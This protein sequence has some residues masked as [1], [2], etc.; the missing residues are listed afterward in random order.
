MIVDR[1]ELMTSLERALLVISDK[2]PTP[3]RCHFENNEIKF[4]CSG[5]NGKFSDEMKA[6][7]SG[8]AMEIGFKCKYLID[9]L[10]VIDDEKVKLQMGGSL[11][12]M[13]IVPLNGEQYTYLV[14][15]VRLKQN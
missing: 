2:V 14:L 13:K 9:P 11:L 3:I 1:R 6:D 12:P 10:K 8:P 15:P 5:E 7:I 4:S